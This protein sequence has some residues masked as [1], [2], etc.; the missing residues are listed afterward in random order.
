MLIGYSY[1]ELY[2]PVKMP[3][4]CGEPKYVALSGKNKVSVG[5]YPYPYRITYS[6]FAYTLQL[7]K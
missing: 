2:V 4:G 5:L 1:P 7:S 6:S 3:E